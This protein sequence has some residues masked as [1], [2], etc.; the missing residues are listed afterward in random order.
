MSVPGIASRHGIPPRPE[1]KTLQVQRRAAQFIDI[2]Q[3][4]IDRIG[5]HYARY[6]QA[7]QA[8]CHPE[9][10]NARGR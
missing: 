9:S 4:D 5:S 7:L 3:A 6:G 2:Q 10:D 1:S 8:R